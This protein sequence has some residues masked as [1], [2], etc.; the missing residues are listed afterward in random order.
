MKQNKEILARL[1]FKNKISQSQID[2]L[3]KE[4]DSFQGGIE[5]YLL[6]N[7]ICSEADL[8]SVIAGTPHQ[9]ADG[10]T[11]QLV[12]VLRNGAQIRAAHR[13]PQQHR[14][15]QRIHSRLF[16]IHFPHQLETEAAL[17]EPGIPA[18]AQYYAREKNL[19]FDH[20]G[21]LG[22]KTNCC[23]SH[24][25]GSALKAPSGRELARQSRD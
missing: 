19:C 3:E 12:Q 22:G 15:Q 6:S 14:G 2:V 16:F 20:R 11:V 13:A 7:K 9:R 17:L 5:K 10:S 4:I 1:A 18:V 21:L 23:L 24:W 8:Y 25:R